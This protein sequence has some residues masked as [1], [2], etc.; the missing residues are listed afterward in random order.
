M[1]LSGGYGVF[2]YTLI[3]IAF[4]VVLGAKALADPALV[5]PNAIFV[6]FA[7]VTSHCASPGPLNWL[8]RELPT[9]PGQGT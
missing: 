2:I 7:S 3:P 4:L 6:T 8:R 5:D 1:T 9:V